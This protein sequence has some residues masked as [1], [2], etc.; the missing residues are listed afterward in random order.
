[1]PV[2]AFI[3]IV[4]F[5]VRFTVP[6]GYKELVFSASAVSLYLGAA[7]YFP[8]TKACTESHRG[9]LPLPKTC[10]VLDRFQLGLKRKPIAL[11][12]KLSSQSHTSQ[13]S[14]IDLVAGAARNRSVKMVK[15][16]YTMNKASLSP[17]ASRGNCFC[18]WVDCYDD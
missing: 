4:T 12:K 11:I 7:V 9:I 18:G 5:V 6:G 16:F 14:S 3:V 10:N 17:P 15:A 1:M 13:S 2:V 8:L